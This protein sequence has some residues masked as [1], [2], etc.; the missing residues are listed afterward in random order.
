MFTGDYIRI[1][2]NLEVEKGVDTSEM[3]IACSLTDSYDNSVVLW[4]SDEMPHD[5]SKLAN[6]TLS[7]EIPNLNLRPNIYY[8]DFQISLKDTD[9][10][11]FC[12]TMHSAVQIHVIPEAFYMNGP[13]LSNIRGH[14]SLIP[15][16][17]L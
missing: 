1:E 3:I 4:V 15:A 2:F 12:D 13:V 17:F 7:L 9:R 8:L 16:T 14:Q 11:N 6:N 5:F 10:N